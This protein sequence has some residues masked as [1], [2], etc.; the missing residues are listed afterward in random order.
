MRFLMQQLRILKISQAII[1]CL[2]LSL[3]AATSAY[4]QLNA[5]LLGQ[6]DPFEGINRYADVWGEGNYAYLASYNGSGLMIVDI[7]N[8]RAPVLAGFYEPMGGA[9]IVDVVVIDGIA[10]C[11]CESY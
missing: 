1:T 8:P 5:K 7:S 11:A 2:L 3:C 6:L 10:Y 9:V 4:A